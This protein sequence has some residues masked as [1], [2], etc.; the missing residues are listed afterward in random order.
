[1]NRFYIGIE[2]IKSRPKGRGK[3]GRNERNITKA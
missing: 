2:K 1:M 3:R